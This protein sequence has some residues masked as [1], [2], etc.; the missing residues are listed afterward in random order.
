MPIDS[1]CSILT[2]FNEK[3]WNEVAKS[4]IELLDKN[5]PDNQK[6]FLYHE[7]NSIPTN[8]NFSN[9]VIWK[10][11]YTESPDIVSF[12][13]KWKNE[14]RANGFDGTNFKFN[15]VKFSHKTFAIWNCYK[16]IESGYLIWL[17]CDACLF[18]E[19]DKNFLNQI[20]PTQEVVSYL[21][22]KGKYSECGF[23]AFNLDHP[24]T[25]KFL[26][27]W[28]DLFLSGEFINLQETHD[29][30]TF[31]HLRLKWNNPEL[32]KDLNK[33]STTDKNPFGNSLLGSHFIH[34]KGAGKESKLGKFI[35][36]KGVV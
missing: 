14:P 33:N 5:W 30:F 24:L 22:R 12:S 18:K 21:G 13:E 35:S 28:E 9:R 29:S 7:L 36:K 27:E 17:D 15:A 23:L 11:L 16:A 31:D 20:L 34:A 3:Y 6:I 2:S 32:F 4:T 1:Q 26:K 19:I 25:R 10:D 8:I